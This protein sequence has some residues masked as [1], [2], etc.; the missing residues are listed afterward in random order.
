MWSQCIPDYLRHI[1]SQ[2]ILI[3]F[4]L[5]LHLYFHVVNPSAIQLQK[6][7]FNA[8]CKGAPT[9]LGKQCITLKLYSL[10]LPQKL[11]K[12]QQNLWILLKLALHFIY[13]KKINTIFFCL[14][15]SVSL[16]WFFLICF[17]LIL[18]HSKLIIE[19]WVFQFSR[20]LNTRFLMISLVT[21]IFGKL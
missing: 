15:H 3:T 8:S 9:G 18:M 13:K 6:M 20:M 5:Y 17:C 19:F 11:R 7:H 12:T 21:I 1:W 4:W 16:S 14:L 10:R 2:S